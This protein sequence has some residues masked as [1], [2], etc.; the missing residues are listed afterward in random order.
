MLFVGFCAS[1]NT[2]KMDIVENYETG[3]ECLLFSGVDRCPSRYPSSEMYKCKSHT[4]I[5]LNEINAI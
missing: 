5:K 3:Y 4:F 1:Y 2:E